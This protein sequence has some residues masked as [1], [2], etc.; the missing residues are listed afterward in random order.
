V[1]LDALDLGQ[2][3]DLLGAFDVQI[4]LGTAVLLSD[5]LELDQRVELVAGRRVRAVALE[6]AAFLAAPV[7]VEQPSG[8]ERQDQRRGDLIIKRRRANADVRL[9]VTG[10]TGPRHRA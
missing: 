4:L 1:E 2:R 8:D 3:N 9:C 6:K 7:E 10:F 5:R